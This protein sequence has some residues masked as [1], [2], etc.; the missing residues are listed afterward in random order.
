MSKLDGHKYKEHIEA[1]YTE[2][3]DNTD[4]AHL[5]IITWGKE[6]LPDYTSDNTPE[7]H[8]K[9]YL[10]YLSLYDPSLVNKYERLRNVI[11]FRE[12]AKS[13]VTNKLFVPY[14]MANNG[15]TIKVRKIKAVYEKGIIVDLIYL[16]ETFE[17]QINEKLIAIVSETATPAED[18]VAGI[19]NEFTENANLIYYYNFEIQDAVDALTG[20]WTKKAFKL[21]GC[22][23]IG[24]GS[25][26]QVRGKIKGASRPSLMIFDDMY[27]ENNTSETGRSKIK[28]WFFDAA[29]NSIDN[30]SGK[31]IVIN[32]IVHEDT[33][34]VLLKSNKLWKTIEIPVMP[35]DNFHKFI[36]EHL[37]SD[38]DTGVCM[39]PFDDIEDEDI[40]RSR[41]QEYFTNLEKL[42]WKLAWKERINLYLL[43]L[44]YQDAVSVRNISGLYQEYF[45]KVMSP[46]DK[47]FKKEFFQYI[48]QWE[49]KHEFG[50]NWIRLNNEETSDGQPHWRIIAIDFGID[51]S[52]GEG[53]DDGVIIPQGTLADDRIIIFPPAVGKFSYRDD[54]VCST[55]EDR[56]LD[57]VLLTR[58]GIAKAGI[59]DEAFRLALRYYPDQIKIGIAGEEKAL[60]KEFRRVFEANK[61]YT[62]NIAGRPQTAREKEKAERIRTTLL[63]YYQTR[64]VYHTDNSLELEY[65][66]E[67]LGKASKDDIADAAEAAFWNKTTPSDISYDFF[68]DAKAQSGIPV[69]LSAVDWD[70]RTA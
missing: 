70:F 4:P 34:P 44:K 5:G 7:F 21:N 9:L 39:L 65:Q 57:K 18:T 61:L 38:Y 31:G 64:M 50:Y 36:Q 24:L 20:E 48:K 46:Q 68:A 17:V 42:D 69:E 19:R 56:R 25:G 23:L 59:I 54:F 32:T 28:K 63:S 26:Q 51:L 33:V 52:S 16:D 6:L 41:Q 49:L 29:I 22:Y 66:L 15:K 10:L 45:H 37:N 62:I 2:W 30:K 58:D 53:K 35:L 3:L 12:G 60:L 11:I 13:T 8:I 47:Q 40:R 27:S 1:K 55:G 14:I 67:Y 43:A